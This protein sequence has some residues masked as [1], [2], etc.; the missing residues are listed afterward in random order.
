LKEDLKEG[1]QVL[2]W[3]ILGDKVIKQVRQQ[4]G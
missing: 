1:V 2:Y 3:I 4:N